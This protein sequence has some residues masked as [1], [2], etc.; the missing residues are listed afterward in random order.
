MF[1]ARS[2]STFET[3]SSPR[4][5]TCATRSRA[6]LDAIQGPGV[7][8]PVLVD[9][10]IGIGGHEQR[11]VL[12]RLDVPFPGIEHLLRDQRLEEDIREVHIRCQRSDIQR[13]AGIEEINARAG[14]ESLVEIRAATIVPDVIGA[15]HQCRNPQDLGPR[16]LCFRHPDTGLCSSHDQRPG[17]GEPQRGGEVDRKPIVA[18]LQRRRFQL[19]GHQVRRH[20]RRIHILRRR[21][22]R[23][24]DRPCP[25]RGHRHLRST[26]RARERPG[27]RRGHTC[28]RAWTRQRIGLRLLLGRHWRDRRR[29]RRQ[30]G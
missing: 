4:L 13:A 16:E 23:R 8:A 22:R 24:R 2:T 19:H 10:E 26:R 27:P 28:R 3:S 18:R 7:H 5:A 12:R 17:I 14:H 6:P 25:R 1:K 21:R 9:A 11:V 15:H 20:A 29:R 30:R